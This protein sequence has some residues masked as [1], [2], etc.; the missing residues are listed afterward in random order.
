MTGSFIHTHREYGGQ[1]TETRDRGRGGIEGGKEGTTDVSPGDFSK[2][3][4][5]F[6]VL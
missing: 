3:F 6:E 1:K 5:F 4:F 2:I